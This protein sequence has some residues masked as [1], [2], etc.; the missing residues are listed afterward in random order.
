MFDIVKSIYH[1]IFQDLHNELASLAESKKGAKTKT[2][3]EAALIPYN[4]KVATAFRHNTN[5]VRFELKF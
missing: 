4:T 3:D 2:N 5:K 1:E